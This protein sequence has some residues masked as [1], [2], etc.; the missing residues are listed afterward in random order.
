MARFWWRRRRRTAPFVDFVVDFEEWPDGT[1]RVS[2]DSEVG[3]GRGPFTLPL[4]PEEVA[5]FGSE[6]GVCG[7]PGSARSA[8]NQEVQEHGRSLGQRLYH[9]LFSG[10][11]ALAWERLLADEE[12]RIRILLRG[13]LEDGIAPIFELP[14]EYLHDGQSFLALDRRFSIVRQ[15]RFPITERRRP[16]SGPLNVLLAAASPAAMPS[17]AIETE[18]AALAD[19]WRIRDDV[20]TH[21]LV[22]ASPE[23]LVSALS[24][25]HLLHFVG[26]GDFH[27]RTGEG[28][29]ILH[30]GKGG[31]AHL[32]GDRLAA[33]LYEQRDLYGVVLNACWTARSRGENPY[34][35]VASALLRAGVPAVLAMQFAICDRE[36]IA[37]S[38]RFHE[39]VAAG[40]PP[41][42]AVISA[43]KKIRA[44]DPDSLAWGIPVLF[45][46]AKAPQLVAP[47]RSLEDLDPRRWGRLL[48]AGWSR[49]SQSLG[50][51]RGRP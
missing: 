34:G 1:F 2:V 33:E 32:S 28:R 14:W 20:E 3:R 49:S 6:V 50:G 45:L 23:T 25:V 43:R 42:E 24:G 11:I 27:P 17:L 16:P 21:T 30:D 46:L 38:T 19:A 37:F 10:E 35:G 29:L 8:W 47:R 26:H 18:L 48:R 7:Q 4:S 41:E 12:V 15:L 5:L 44:E 22:A 13:R 40:K 9:A 39:G 36:A 51:L 31:E